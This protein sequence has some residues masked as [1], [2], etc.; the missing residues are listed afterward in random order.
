MDKNTVAG[1]KKGPPSSLQN[2]HEQP[3]QGRIRLLYKTENSFHGCPWPHTNT[4][5][6]VHAKLGP[7][8]FE[9]AS[10]RTKF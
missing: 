9:T 2:K 6:N 1:L 5:D 8:T 4:G 3:K 7:G 10:F